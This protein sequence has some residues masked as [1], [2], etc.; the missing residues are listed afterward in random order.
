MASHSNEAGGRP[1]EESGEP[2]PELQSDTFLT[3]RRFPLIAPR[4]F[5]DEQPDEQFNPAPSSQRRFPLVHSSRPR[6][7][8]NLSETSTLGELTTIAR[9]PPVAPRRLSSEPSTE[10]PTFRDR[11]L[12]FSRPLTPQRP[13]SSPRVSFGDAWQPEQPPSRGG[14]GPPR[15]S[16]MAD[17][18][19]RRSSS[20]TRRVSIVEPPPPLPGSHPLFNTNTFGRDPT[21]SQPRKL[22]VA[23]APNVSEPRRPSLNPLQEEK[24][25]RRVSFAAANLRD[26]SFRSGSVSGPA[27]KD[28]AKSYAFVPRRASTVTAQGRQVRSWSIAGRLVS[29]GEKIVDLDPDSE[30]FQELLRRQSLSKTIRRGSV[31]SLGYY[32][33]KHES[34]AMPIGS[35]DQKLINTFMDLAKERAEQ[36]KRPPYMAQVWRYGWWMLMLAFLYLVFVGMPLWKGAVWASW[37]VLSRLFAT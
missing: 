14:G 13:T 8:R 35:T 11:S 6:L 15:R 36:F 30:D 22:S 24:T 26:W 34:A 1:S 32:V 29:N 18:L 17:P 27:T 5:Q 20:S 33:R 10:I 37:Y 4:P 16:S 31:T 19:A 2:L 9:P 12:S 3:Q 7:Q 21:T 25:T 28:R 23:V